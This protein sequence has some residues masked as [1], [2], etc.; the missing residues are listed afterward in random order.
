[1]PRGAERFETAK[2]PPSLPDSPSDEPTDADRAYRGAFVT[3]TPLSAELVEEAGGI[4][5]CHGTPRLDLFF[6]ARAEALQRKADDADADVL[7]YHDRQFAVRRDGEHIKSI[8]SCAE[9]AWRRLYKRAIPQGDPLDH[10]GFHRFY[11]RAQKAISRT[12]LVENL[13]DAVD[14]QVVTDRK[15]RCRY[16]RRMKPSDAVREAARG[17]ETAAPPEALP[18]TAP[19]DFALYGESED[20]VVQMERHVAETEELHRT[21]T[22]GVTAGELNGPRRTSNGRRFETRHARGCD[23]RPHYITVGRW[24]EDE[25]D[26][27]GD[28]RAVR[29]SWMIA[30]I[31]GRTAG[32]EKDRDRS[33]RLARRLLH[34]LDAFGVDLGDVVVSYSGNASTHVRIP[35]GAVGCPIYRSEKAATS[36]LCRFFDRLCGKD[37]KLREAI[38]N[39]ILRPGQLIR[40]VGSI[41]EATGRRT[42]ATDGRTFLDKPACFLW[43]LSEPQFRYTRHRLSLPRRS[44]FVAPLASL[45]FSPESGVS[46]SSSNRVVSQSV[47]GR[48]SVVSRVRHGVGRG[49][50]FGLDCRGRQHMEGRNWAAL[51]YSH[52]ALAQAETRP[53]A[54]DA[55]RRWNKQNAPPLQERELRGVFDRAMRYQVRQSRS[56]RPT[57][58]TDHTDRKSVV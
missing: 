26:E 14:P 29:V 35:D 17:R 21:F 9:D 24:R 1:M 49:E 33:D 5:T 16:G 20:A 46:P 30:E 36:A 53:A 55:V 6:A 4:T 12:D 27:T 31:D 38:D 34:R 57:A 56:W 58:P 42:V 45:L 41:H 13:G 52:H 32:G 7:I 43:H 2:D 3:S 19:E 8:Q 54:W 39:A 44:A 23:D 51:V 11:R 37:T 10:D 18:C 28:T 25:V 15:K 40:A 47:S 50:P 22:H 48:A